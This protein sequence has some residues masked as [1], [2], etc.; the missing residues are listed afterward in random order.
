MSL[1]RFVFREAAI[2]FA[3]TIS[4]AALG[5]VIVAMAPYR[6]AAA[7]LP[8][9]SLA[10]RSIGPAISGG[11]VQDDVRPLADREMEGLVG[12]TMHRG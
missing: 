5:S 7:P 10:W 6:A 4:A 2:A 11:R 1:R 12:W 9:A 3:M 8:Y